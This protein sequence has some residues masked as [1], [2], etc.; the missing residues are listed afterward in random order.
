MFRSDDSLGVTSDEVLT[1]ILFQKETATLLA[2]GMNHSFGIDV[3]KAYREA[4][5]FP[6]GSAAVD[7]ED[8]VIHMI[9]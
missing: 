2:D 7:H 8:L 6:D 3:K 5:D 1:K 4:D 9:G